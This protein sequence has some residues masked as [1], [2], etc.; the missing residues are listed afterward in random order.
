[1]EHGVPPFAKGGEG[2]FEPQGLTPPVKIPP[3][4]P[5]SKGGDPARFDMIFSGNH[6]SADGKGVP[7]RQPAAAPAIAA[8]DH[9]R[10]PKPDRK[11]M[12]VLGAA[13][14]IEPHSRTAAAVVESLF[15]DP[16]VPSARPEARRPVPQAKRVCAVL[17]VAAAVAGALAPPRPADVIFPWL[18]E[19]ARRRDPDHTT[20]GC[21]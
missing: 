12:A 2:G 8:H 15:R 19:E 5:F 21:C 18:A 4:P 16:T 13:D 14:P 9:A 3:N 6:L 11:K 17:P 20:P 10:G 1:M 7:L